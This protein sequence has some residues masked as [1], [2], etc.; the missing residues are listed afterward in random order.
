MVLGSLWNGHEVKNPRVKFCCLLRDVNEST[1]S[2][3]A[4]EQA[5]GRNAGCLETAELRTKIIIV[6]H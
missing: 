1:G 4:A 2:A 5:H 3:E 6:T